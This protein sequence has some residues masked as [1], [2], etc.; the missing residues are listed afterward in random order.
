MRQIFPSGKI[1]IKLTEIEIEKV[2]ISYEELAAINPDWNF[3][4]VETKNYIQ[5][6]MKKL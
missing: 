2:F 3:C 5:M 4:G 6:S 1:K